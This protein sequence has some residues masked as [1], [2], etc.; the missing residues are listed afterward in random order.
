[1]T[2][3]YLLEIESQN[4]KFNSK[5]PMKL[6]QFS[7]KR[8]QHISGHESVSECR[9]N[10]FCFPHSPVF[11]KHMNRYTCSQ[12]P[13]VF[14]VYLCGNIR[15]NFNIPNEKTLDKKHSKLEHVLYRTFCSNDDRAKNLCKIL[16][17]YFF[18]CVFRL[19]NL[20]LSSLFWNGR[21]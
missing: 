16:K 2:P 8:F 4:V 15:V 11:F 9:K 19:F 20:A 6:L 7:V 12:S 18:K 3:F 17:I 13:Q 21:N 14:H 10:I 1:M 5:L